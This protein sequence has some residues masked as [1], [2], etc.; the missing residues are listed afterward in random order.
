MKLDFIALIILEDEIL[1]AME[2]FINVII[3][4]LKGNYMQSPFDRALNLYKLVKTPK[5]NMIAVL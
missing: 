5:I 2:I 1:P 3:G 4:R